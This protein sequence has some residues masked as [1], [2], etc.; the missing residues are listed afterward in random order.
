MTVL[1][2]FLIMYLSVLLG[3]RVGIR[4]TSFLAPKGLWKLVPFRISGWRSPITGEVIS[5]KWV[6]ARGT[7]YEKKN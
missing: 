1:I 7:K 6:W 5:S 2:I 3:C 4:T